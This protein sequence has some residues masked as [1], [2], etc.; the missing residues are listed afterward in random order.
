MLRKFR[1]AALALA[2]AGLG[3]SAASAQ[4]FHG[5]AAAGREFALHNCDAC[6]IV[7]TN[8]DLRPLIGGYAPSFFD[9]ANRPNVSAGS[10]R[11]FLNRQHA[12]TNMPYPDLTPR[13]LADVVAY[14]LTL[15][16]KQS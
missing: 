14:I 9:V 16:G 10:L 4:D 1:T 7:S 15:H 3:A 11:V 13:D 6:H 5:N 2:V 12:Y 8:Q